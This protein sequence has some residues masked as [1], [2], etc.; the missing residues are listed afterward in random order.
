MI[1]DRLR[2]LIRHRAKG[3]C[4]YCLC[5]SNLTS[6]PFHCEHILP[7]SA[8]GETNLDNL[9]WACPSC[10]QQKSTKTQAIDP[11][12]LN[13]YPLFHPRLQKWNQHFRWSK[14]L[15][16]IVGKTPIGRATV[17]ALNLNRQ[18]I[19]NLR[20]LLIGVGEH[21]PKIEQVY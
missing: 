7:H 6:A 10:N 3:Y 9:A 19:I 2:S 1:S 20:R 11:Q 14:D 16:L 4:E 21:P 12:S 18:E 5:P 17:E 8:G 13:P 15:M